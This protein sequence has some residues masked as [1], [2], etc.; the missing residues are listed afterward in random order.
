MSLAIDVEKVVQVLLVD[1]WHTVKPKSF[2]IDAYEYL[3]Y[4]DNPSPD[5]DG[6]VLLGGGRDD[7]IASH[8]FVFTETGPAPAVIAGPL[9][10]VLAV[11]SKP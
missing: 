5:D 11:K 7:H 1:G 8:G 9:T 10:S 4:P 3:E 2:S 6:F